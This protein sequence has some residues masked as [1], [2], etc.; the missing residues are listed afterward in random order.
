M[1]PPIASTRHV[2][3]STFA[4]GNKALLVTMPE[5]PEDSNMRMAAEGY[6]KEAREVHPA[7]ACL[8]AQAS[9]NLAQRQRNEGFRQNHPPA[10][11]RNHRFFHVE[12][13]PALPCLPPQTVV[14]LPVTFTASSPSITV[15]IPLQLV[16]TAAPKAP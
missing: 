16:A 8:M 12:A 13:T 2:P 6:A 10:L 7:P 9:L 5:N 15:T 4:R 14:P 1:P 3:T 11:L